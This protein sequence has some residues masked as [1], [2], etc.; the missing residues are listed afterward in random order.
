MSALLPGTQVRARGRQWE[1]VHAEPAG[2]RNGFACA[3]SRA[4]CAGWRSASCTPSAFKIGG[5]WRFRFA[6]IDAWIKTR[7]RQVRAVEDKR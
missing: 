2:S 7:T 1:V 6:G 5:S 4:T 3:A